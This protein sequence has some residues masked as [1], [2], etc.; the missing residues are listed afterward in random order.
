MRFFQREDKVIVDKPY[1]NCC[2]YC[3][4][5]YTENNFK[6]LDHI[7]PLNKRISCG[8]KSY[9]KQSVK[10]LSNIIDCCNEC[11]QLKSNKTLIKWLQLL[12]NNFH[13][14]SHRRN[15]IKIYRDID[16]IRMK[17]LTILINTKPV[18]YLTLGNL[19]LEL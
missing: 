10:K 11:N 8:R 15:K 7:Q 9:Y 12:Q 6:T 4:R 2:S 19:N 1:L 3:E 5:E 14:K 13:Y 16:I 17:N 18:P